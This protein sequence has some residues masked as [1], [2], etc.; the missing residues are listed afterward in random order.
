[1]DSHKMPIKQ[2]FFK[3]KMPPSPSSIS[4]PCMK[5][6][7]QENPRFHPTLTSFLIFYFAF[8]IHGGKQSLAVVTEKTEITTL[9]TPDF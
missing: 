2:L 4:F 9:K 1:M 7:I 6:F 5:T 8:A 3:L